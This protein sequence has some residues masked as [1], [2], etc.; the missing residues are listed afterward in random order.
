MPETLSGCS[1]ERPLILSLEQCR[2]AQ[3]DPDGR[4]HIQLLVLAA[5]AH[6]V[7]PR[8]ELN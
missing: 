8:P 4:R 6:K 2:A 7:N 5:Y 1:T 3:T